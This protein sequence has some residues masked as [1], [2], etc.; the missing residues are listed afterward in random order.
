MRIIHPKEGVV[1]KN[2]VIMNRECLNIIAATIALMFF[3]LTQLKKRID[4]Q[5]T[6]L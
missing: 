2:V 3:H 4:Y 6:L 5:F 1:K